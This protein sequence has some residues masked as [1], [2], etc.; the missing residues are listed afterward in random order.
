ML[1]VTVTVTVVI[2]K[3]LY[4]SFFLMDPL[5]ILLNWLT[6]YPVVFQ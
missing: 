2:E 5:F 1:T 4:K 3:N 6:G